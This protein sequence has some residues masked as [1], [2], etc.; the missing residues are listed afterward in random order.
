MVNAIKF[1]APKGAITIDATSEGAITGNGVGVPGDDLPHVFDRFYRCHSGGVMA[2]PGPGLA[3]VKSIIEAHR[4][5]APGE[6]PGVG[7]TR[8][9]GAAPPAESGERRP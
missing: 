3:T 1:T 7:T 6:E 8:P 9:A 5:R 4:D 2:V